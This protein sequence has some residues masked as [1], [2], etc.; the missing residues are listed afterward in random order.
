MDTS[1]S[2]VEVNS[3]WGLQ[4]GWCVVRQEFAVGDGEMYPSGNVP[5]EGEEFQE[6]SPSVNRCEG[7]ALHRNSG[8]RSGS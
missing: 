5:E 2:S 7:S 4:C 3:E 6:Q 8:N 1:S